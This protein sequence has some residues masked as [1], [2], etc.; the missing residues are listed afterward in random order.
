MSVKVTNINAAL[1]EWAIIRSG[2][3]LEDFYAQNPNVRSWTNGDKVPTV[4]QLESFTNKVHV[5]FGYMFLT[6]PPEERIPLPFFRTGSNEIS[7]KVSLNVYH[8]IQIIKE[9][10]DWLRD[11]LEELEYPDLDFVGKYS[12]NHDYRVIVKAIKDTLHLSSGWAEKQNSWERALEYLTST[13]EEAGMIVSFNGVVGSNNY[14]AIDVKEC[15]GFVLVDKK[16]PFLFINS[17][18]TK[19]AQMFSLVHELAHIF[20]GESA[21][22][23][24]DK[25]LPASTPLENL[26]DKVA[27]EFLVPE[28]FL[29]ERWKTTRDFNV[30]S[31]VFKVSPIVIARRALD[32]SLIN[33]AQFFRFY[34]NYILEFN[35][36]KELSSSGGN[37]YTTVR[38]RISLRFAVFVNN[39][40]KENKLLYRDAYRLTNMTGN[41]YNKFVTEYLY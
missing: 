18:D 25:L 19:A 16:A 39:A 4:K 21:G 8:T 28:S 6:T 29:L 3:S 14:R 10:Q 22:F 13:I 9:R 5:P 37:Y 40:V 41:S 12:L 2:N 1:I 38:K 20:I 34:N 23:N 26:C 15:R 7:K 27:A 32:L 17:S 33:K 31:R 30:L 11:Y 35:F 24:N 36:R